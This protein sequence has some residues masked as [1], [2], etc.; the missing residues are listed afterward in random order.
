MKAKKILV[1]DDDPDFIQILRIRL[2]ASGYRVT[3]A[4]DGKE[5]LEIIQAERPDAVLLDIRMPKL[6]GLKVLGKIRRIDKKLPIFMLTAF[7]SEERFGL[8][9]RLDASGFIVKTGDL[10]KQIT[11]ITS[12]L[13]LSEKFRKAS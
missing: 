1:V 4:R 12:A 7:S 6:D 11:N 8:A 2:K 3:V 5:A 9:K 13:S 10:S